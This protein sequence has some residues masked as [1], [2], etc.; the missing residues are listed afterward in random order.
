MDE[1]E[2]KWIK[3]TDSAGDKVYSYMADDIRIHAVLAKDAY[4]LEDGTKLD[5]W[6]HSDSTNYYLKD[7][8]ELLVE[9]TPCGPDNSYVVGVYSL[10]TMP[11]EAQ[12]KVLTYYEEQGLIYDVEA[13]L[14]CA[15]KALNMKI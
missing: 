7:G 6:D 1:V 2:G 9:Q 11:E 3:V 15:Y 12:E 8:T 13:E 14:E 10:D 4:I 5:I